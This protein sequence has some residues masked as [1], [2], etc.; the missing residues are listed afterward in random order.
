MNTAKILHQTEIPHR[1]PFLQTLRNLL[2]DLTV[3]WRAFRES[4]AR[5]KATVPNLRA[6]EIDSLYTELC[7]LRTESPDRTDLIEAKFARL[8]ELQRQEAAEIRRRL[9]ASFSLVPGSGYAALREAKQL[10]GPDENPTPSDSAVFQQ[11]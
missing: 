5:R 2:L 7:A 8:R 3:G 10:L 11:S 1:G 9:E 4:R 6:Q